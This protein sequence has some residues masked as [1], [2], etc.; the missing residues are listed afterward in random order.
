M[1]QYHQDQGIVLRKYIKYDRDLPGGPVGKNP[2][3][4]AGDTGSIPAKRR[5]HMPQ[6]N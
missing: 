5:S 4:T 1:E 6:S 2:P 3:A